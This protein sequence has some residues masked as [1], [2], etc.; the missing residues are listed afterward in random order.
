MNKEV[1]A[2]TNLERTIFVAEFELSFEFLCS[3][4]KN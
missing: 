1:N 4:D 2:R 3:L